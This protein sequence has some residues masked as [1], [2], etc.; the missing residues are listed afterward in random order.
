MMQQLWLV[1]AARNQVLPLHNSPLPLL[2]GWG[3][4]TT[5]P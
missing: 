5:E 2:T 1:E 4:R 3:R